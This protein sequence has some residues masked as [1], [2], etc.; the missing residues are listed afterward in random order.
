MK[1]CLKKIKMHLEIKTNKREELID[2]TREVEDSLQK[3]KDKEKG[4]V[5][6]F[7]PHAT[8]G[9]TINENADSNL[10]KD[11]SNFLSSTVPK[12]KWMHDRIDNN[13]DAHIKTS[14]IGNSVS[15]PFEN[16]KLILGK[17]QDIFLCEFDGPRKREVILNFIKQD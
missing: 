14:L 17:W 13:A 12:G 11:I 8:A 16:G 1:S 5:H 4:I 15:V 9:I 3:E 2:I 7:I 6:V 10:P